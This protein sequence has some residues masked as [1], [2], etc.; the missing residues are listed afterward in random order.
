MDE[1]LI[2]CGDVELLK[3]IVAEL[4]DDEFKPIATKT[5]EGILDK[6]RGRN[7]GV[8]LVHEHL[9]DDS[10][11]ALCR[12]LKQLDPAP[13]VVFL[14]DPPP[15]EGP[16]DT[17]IRFPVPGPVLRNAIDRVRTDDEEGDDLDKWKAFYGEVKER[18]GKVSD[19]DYYQMLGLSPDAPHHAVVK[20]FDQVSLRYHPDRYKQFRDRRWGEALHEKINQLYTILTEAYQV[21]SDRQLRQRYDQLRAGGD[22]RMP[23]DELSSPESGPSSLTEAANSAKARKFLGM[24]QTEIAKKNWEAALQ[25]LEFAASMEPDNERISQKIEEIEAKQD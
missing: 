6:I 25:N 5:G 11:L 1:I 24:A 13:G 3:Q 21:L 10:A 7:V 17:A 4:P 12:G 15:Q 14:A 2:A 16:F 22:L 8:A 9:A 20:S 19:Q 18:L 23:P